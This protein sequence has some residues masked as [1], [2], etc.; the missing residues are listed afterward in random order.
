MTLNDKKQKFPTIITLSA[1][2]KAEAR[3]YYDLV[4]LFGLAFESE[5]VEVI[6]N[7]LKIDKL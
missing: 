4:Y 7:I 3:L 6:E 1:P 5:L 2:V